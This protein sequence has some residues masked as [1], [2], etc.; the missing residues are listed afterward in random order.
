MK[1]DFYILGQ[2]G[3]LALSR[4][5][6]E[7]ESQYI[8]VVIA[9]RD[10]AIEKDYFD[11]IEDLCDSFGITFYEKGK[12]KYGKYESQYVFAIGWRWI[13]NTSKT[14]IVFHDS[15]LP[16]Y[17]GFSPLVNMLINQEEE[18]GVTALIASDEYDKGDILGQASI[19]VSYP[20]KIQKAI[21]L[22]SAVYGDLVTSIYRLMKSNIDLHGSQQDESLATYS[23]WRNEDDYLINWEWDAGK[24]KRFCDAVGY[25]YKGARTLAGDDEL[26][27]NDALVVADIVI[28]SRCDHIGKIIFFDGGHPIVV[29]GS[30][31]LKLVNYSFKSQEEK[32]LSFR[33][34]FK[35]V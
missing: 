3:F 25:P 4:F 9:A 34:R 33:T 29:C 30:G 19:I 35:S 11:E 31:L 7:N 13:I 28:E 32:K 17:R 18:I 23:L 1:V 10:P 6:E 22:I 16:K 21:D 26:I 20:I 15:L 14:L 24:I 2:K 5:C 27:I 8:G 12:Q